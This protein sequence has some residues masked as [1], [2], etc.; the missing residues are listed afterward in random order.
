MLQVTLESAFAKNDNNNGISDNNKQIIRE[1]AMV[2]WSAPRLS[3]REVHGSNP[4]LGI[5]FQNLICD[6]ANKS[7]S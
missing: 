4:T 7:T 5:L 2:E 1:V 3:D 6:L